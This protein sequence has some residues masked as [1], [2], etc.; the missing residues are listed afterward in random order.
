MEVDPESVPLFGGDAGAV[1]GVDEFEICEGLVLRKT[2]AHLMS[3]YILAFRRPERP[4]RH[5]S[6]PWK[7]V[8]GGVSL[9]WWT[10]TGPHVPVQLGRVQGA[11]AR[12]RGRAPRSSFAH[13]VVSAA[14]VPAIA[15]A[16]AA[17]SDRHR[18]PVGI[19]FRLGPVPA[20]AP[21]SRPQPFF[22]TPSQALSVRSGS[23]D[24]DAIVVEDPAFPDRVAPLED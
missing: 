5:H 12:G 15:M 6:A 19:G 21:D 16:T 14:A 2:Y 17:R 22:V 20:L 23:P 1:L 13:D 18:C 9:V 10:R 4:G 3:P 7:S 11:R 8:C 24:R